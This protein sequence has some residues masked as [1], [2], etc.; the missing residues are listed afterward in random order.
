MKN[1]GILAI[2]GVLALAVVPSFAQDKMTAA[3]P[4]TRLRAVV[5]KFDNGMA[6]VKTEKGDTAM[7]A[8]GPKTNISGVDARKLSDIKANDFIGITALA[9]KDGKMSATEVH[10]FP[11]PMRGAGEGHYPWDKGPNSSMTNAA[12]SGMVDSTDGKTFTMS[13][14]DKMSGST[15][16]VK[17]DITPTIP[18]VAFVPGDQ[19]LIKAGAHVVIFARKNPDGSLI[20]FAVVAEK[21]GVMP[22]R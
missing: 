22:P 7:V 20:A 2:V 6:T 18:I 12:V 14:K 5:E 19:S 9:D 15:K 8:I 1:L 10:I 3:A 11:P 16:E 21:D 4:P 13:Y 17:I